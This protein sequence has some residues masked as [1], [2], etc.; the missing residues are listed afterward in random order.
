MTPR[1]CLYGHRGRICTCL[2]KARNIRFGEGKVYIKRRQGSGRKNI[3]ARVDLAVT[4]DSSLAA[5]VVVH[6]SILRNR[7]IF[8][9]QV[10]LSFP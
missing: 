6:Q 10:L 1:S 8:I 9:V 5:E 7:I 2:V 4:L 3:K